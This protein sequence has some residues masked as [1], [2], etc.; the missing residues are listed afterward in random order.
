MPYRNPEIVT[1]DYRI[2]TIFFTFRATEANKANPLPLKSKS[3]MEQ[4]TGTSLFELQVDNVASAYL[5]EAARWAKFLAILGFILCGFIVLIALF[6]GSI[7]ATAFG[8]LG[9]GRTGLIGGAGVSILYIAFS[10]L[11]FFPCL[12]LYNFASK[13]QVALRSNDQEFLNQSFKN[14]KSCYRF[15]GIL[16]VVYLGLCALGLIFMIIGLASR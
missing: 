6:A 3:F 12:Y 1:I 13:M 2:V 5:K 11:Y 15:I 8:T 14:L 9:A 4:N 10:L 7:M 16:M